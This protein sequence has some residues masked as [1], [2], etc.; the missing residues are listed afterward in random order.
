MLASFGLYALR[1]A[2]P[3]GVPD[4]L[5]GGA[6]P[7]VVLVLAALALLLADDVRELRRRFDT[8]SGV[9]RSRE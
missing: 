3:A 1:R 6:R 2:R 9:A 4:V 7:V 5:T 8:R